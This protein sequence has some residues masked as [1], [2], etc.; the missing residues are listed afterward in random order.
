M[1]RYL[2]VAT[3]LARR[4]RSGELAVGAELP[5]VRTYADELGATS[6]TV[7]RAYRHLADAD[8]ITV[9]DRRRARVATDGVLAAARLLEA[10]R[11]FRLAGSDDP[12]LQILLDRTTPAV[13]PVGSRGSFQGLRALARGDADGAAIHLRHHTGVYNS[14]F[15]RALLRGKD[16]H[17]LHL[18]RRQQGLLVPH[19]DQSG[20]RSVADL[21]GKLVARRQ[22]GAGTRVL[23]E[24]LLIGAGI[25]PHTVHGP[26]LDSHLE[27][28]LAVAAGI[29]DA[30]L[31]LRATATDLGLDF[32]PLTWESYD[33]V[34][35][36]TALGA[37]RSLMT[38]MRDP[39]T[40]AAVADMDGYDLTEVGTLERLDG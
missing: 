21:T 5:A 12:A 19:G 34:L 13:V 28:G 38:A 23:L 10:D 3:E 26:E 16:P 36:G 15:A 32:V 29:A 35:A 2:E 18:W 40:R 25:D 30:A 39:A 4:I 11:V 31:G 24:Q 8:V 22:A 27:T 37:V 1:T 6:S 17:L 7:V 9:A 33:I 20:I 14:P